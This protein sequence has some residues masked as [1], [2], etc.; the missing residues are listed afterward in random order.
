MNNLLPSQAKPSHFNGLKLNPLAAVLLA[1]FS[2][3]P[4]Y[5]AYSAADLPAASRPTPE[6]NAL[7][8]LGKAAP[9][10][11]NTA[12]RAGPGGLAIES[13]F[14]RQ[15]VIL[16]PEY[17]NQTGASLGVT[18]ASMLGEN[19]AVGVLLNL[20]A[21][22]KEYL[23]NAGYK[24]DERQRVIVTAGQLTQFLDYAFLS[25]KENLG[26]TQNSGALSYQLQLG[27]EFLR[28]LEV[29]GYVAKTESRNL[30]DKT[31]AIDSATVFELWNDPRRIAG[32]QV[33]G[34]QGKLGFSPLKDSLIKVSL[35]QEQLKYDLQSGDQRLNRATGG[36]EWQQRLGGGYQL[37]ASAD[38]YASQNNYKI[39]LERSQLGADGRHSLGLQFN[40]IRGRDGL[41]NDNQFK[42]TYSLIFGTGA[43]G[44]SNRSPNAT[45]RFPATSATSVN[46][47]F[48]TGQAN[49]QMANLLDQVA[50]RPSVIPSHI[51]AKIDQSALPT[52][53][54]AVD[55][56]SLPTGS[57]IDAATG[58]ITTPL[59]VAVTGIAGVTR[60]GAAFANT[61]QFAL[62]GNNLIV[63][64]NQI[65]QPP[66]GVVDTYVVT[67]N[68]QGGGTTLA[69]VL[70]SHGSVKFDS[71]VITQG[72]SADLTAPVTTAAPT[73]SVAATDTTASVTQTINENGTG[74]YLV[75]PAASAAPTVAAVKAGTSFAMTAG[76]PAV[77][78]LTGLTASTAYK[79]YFVAKDAANNDQAAVST[80]LAVTTTA[81]PDLTAPVTTVAPTISVAATD[82]TASI[83][84]TINE[85]GTG[86]YLVLPVASA[87]PTVAAV[88]AGTSF[89]MTAGT[90]AVV[91]L[92]GLTAS[93]AYKYY[94]VAK[95][96][97]NNDQAA[98]STGLAITTTAAAGL[99]AGYVQQGGLTWTPNTIGGWNGGGGYTDWNTANAYCTS[100]TINGQTGW[101]LPSKD[102][103][104]SLYNS[105]ALSG[106]PGW[107]LD[108]TWSSTPYGA[109]A[110]YDFGLYDGYV[111]FNDDTDYSYVSCVR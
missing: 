3:Y 84:Q 66:V 96:A 24:I 62:A 67:I 9:A 78:S 44:G 34:L 107:E 11:N 68:N 99:P 100:T 32:G 23:L 57:R 59:G 26:L 51:I 39:G 21:D 94:F 6:E 104:V 105:G 52:R 77:V 8:D 60:N 110:H 101:R 64:P 102:E 87:A 31:F 72:G 38:T 42:L 89:A 106:Q 35:G 14:E 75:L 2:L 12:V 86:Y 80:G 111:S 85:N 47:T 22:K 5:P 54:I 56:A 97:A 4:A 29:N 103:L 16:S 73:I 49:G 98:V 46:N 109:G 30:A 48:G 55:K 41:G 45:M 108:E 71:I 93:T 65:T 76:T 61:N 13:R 20:G 19:A 70:I 33:T 82:T 95:D 90:P 1:S 37:N 63:R 81:A 88:K 18:L 53:L 27:E 69:T 17:S 28:F 92:T 15:K 83:T 79:Y 91:S 7:P 50:Q 10:N 36:V 25:G 58:D 43:I 74:Y 40:S